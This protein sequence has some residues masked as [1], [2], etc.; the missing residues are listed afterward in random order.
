MRL[1]APLLRH[2]GPYRL[3][4]SFDRVLRALDAMDD[5]V[6]PDKDKIDVAIRLLVRFPRP[7]LYLRRAKL[8]GDIFDRCIKPSHTGDTSGPQ[9][10]DFTQ[11]AE[12]IYAAFRQAYG[13]DLKAERGRLDWRE[14][15][16]LFEALPDGTVMSEIMS[17]RLRDYPQPDGYNQDEI[18]ALRKA[19]NAFALNIKRK[20]GERFDADIS[21]Q[22]TDMFAYYRKKAGEK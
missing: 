14:F 12:Y 16:A 6:L 1:S 7:L 4:L 22:V 18:A 11:D 9:A 5:D 8:W 15:L 21:A 20:P 2:I 17:I 3:N 13:I 10:F 19:K